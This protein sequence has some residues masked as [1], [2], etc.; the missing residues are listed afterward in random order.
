MIRAQPSF[1]AKVIECLLWESVSQRAVLKQRFPGIDRDFSEWFKVWE[2]SVAKA[3]SW[4][5][6]EGTREDS[7]SRTSF[8]L[9]TTN[10]ASSPLHI[11]NVRQSN[12]VYNSKL[13]RIRAWIFRAHWPTQETRSGFFFNLW[14]QLFRRLDKSCLLQGGLQGLET[15][16]I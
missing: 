10:S 4:A 14:V 8:C 5:R 9:G 12:L 1:A 11:S 7:C 16:T 13:P 2:T 15:K 3:K 6:A